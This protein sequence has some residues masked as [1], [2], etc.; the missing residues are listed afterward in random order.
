MFF[1]PTTFDLCIHFFLKCQA[2]SCVSGYTKCC[3][4]NHEASWKTMKKTNR[5]PVFYGAYIPVGMADS[6]YIDRQGSNR[7][8]HVQWKKWTRCGSIRWE[9]S[10]RRVWWRALF[11]ERLFGLRSGWREWTRQ[12]RS[13]G[14]TFWAE[15]IG[16]AKAWGDKEYLR[17]R[18]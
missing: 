5:I 13:L 18:R 8:W 11:E 15:E 9:A 6:K 12:R 10:H 4:F 14:R 2:F 16:K 1:I 7:W 17:S 3:G